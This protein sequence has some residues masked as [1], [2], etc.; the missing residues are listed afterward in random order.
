MRDGVPVRLGYSSVSAGGLGIRTRSRSVFFD[1]GLP[2][3]NN[4]VL[5]V[6]GNWSITSDVIDEWRDSGPSAAAVSQTTPGN[7][8][9]TTTVGAA[10]RP[11]AL[12]SGSQWMDNAAFSL[13]AAPLTV[14]VFGLISPQTKCFCDGL[15][16]TTV[17]VAKYANTPTQI[18]TSGKTTQIAGVTDITTAKLWITTCNGNGNTST[19]RVNGVGVAS[20]VINGAGFNGLRVGATSTGTLALS[21]AIGLFGV[22]DRAFTAGELTTAETK[23]P[24]YFGGL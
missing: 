7:R 13:P 10:N 8:F 17:R 20:G 2:R 1:L 14:V 9:G 6:G 19:L 18:A 12:G 22:W 15:N 23:I 16:I 4:R 24:A 11:A 3:S 5:L 21:G